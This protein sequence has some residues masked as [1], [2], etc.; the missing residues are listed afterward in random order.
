MEDGKK[1]HIHYTGK[2]D[3]GTT[4]D[5]SEGKDPLVFEMGAKQV[6]PGFENAVKEMKEGEKKSIKIEA[7]D[8]YGE[9][10]PEL[11]Q[12]VPKEALGEIADKVKVGMVLGM[13]HPASPQPIPARVIEV[14]DKTVKMDINHPLAGKN[15][16]F[17]L[18][19]VK[20]E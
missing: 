14:N 13:N 2:L 9:P 17:D 1:V 5:S 16:N 15:L 19:L 12:E 20:I 8:A 4:F 11:I 7:K 10:K 18:E 6:I 3:D